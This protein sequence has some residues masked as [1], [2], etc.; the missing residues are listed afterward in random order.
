MRTLWLAVI[1]MHK[2]VFTRIFTMSFALTVVV[3]LLKAFE[4]THPE[5]SSGFFTLA[6]YFWL[7][8][9]FWTGYQKVLVLDDLYALDAAMSA[10]VTAPRLWERLQ[11]QPRGG[12]QPTV[13]RSLLGAFPWA[14]L[15]PAIPRAALVGFRYSQSFLLQ[16]LLKHLDQR[17]EGAANDG[18][19]LIGACVLVY[20][21]MFTSVAY[22]GYL[23]NR[24]VY[25]TR[26]CL[27]A[28]VYRKT[29][30]L[31]LAQANDASS[32]TLMSTDVEHIGTGLLQMHQIWGGLVEVALG[33]W[34]LHT[35]IGVASVVPL[36]LIVLCTI[37]LYFA[38]M[39]VPARQT[40]WMEKIQTRV[41]LTASAISDMKTFKILGAAGRVA[42]L[43][44]TRRAEEIGAGNQ[45]R[46]LMLASVVLSYMPISLS[47]VVA[48]AATL[49][50]FNVSSLFVSLS[51]IMLLSSPL[52][53]LF[54]AVP[55]FLAGIASFRRIDAYL[56]QPCQSDYR[57]FPSRDAGSGAEAGEHKS[58][59]ATS[60]TSSR[61]D[62]KSD[63]ASSSGGDTR[64]A[65]VATNASFG[66]E[67]DNMI[68]RDLDF[69]I[70]RGVITMI[71]GPTASGKSTLCHALLGEIPIAKGSLTA[72]LPGSAII[73]Y[74]AQTAYLPG[75]TIA[76]NIV[77][78][79]PFSREKY[80]SVLEAAMLDIDV[81]SLPSGHDTDVG[82]NGIKLIGGQKQRVSLARALYLESEISVFDDALSGL[83]AETEGKIFD[84]VFGPRGLI[85][86]KGG[87]A[88]YFTNSSRH[89]ALADHIIVL[90]KDGTI[91]QQGLAEM[92]T[93][94]NNG[95]LLLTDRAS[96]TSADLAMSSDGAGA[97]DDVALKTKG[98]TDEPAQPGGEAENG[99]ILWT[100]ARKTG[101]FTIYL[102]YL[103]STAKLAS[104]LV[105]L[106]S[107][108]A[109]FCT[110]FSTV[111]MSYWAEDSLHRPTAF[112]L[113]IYG[114]LRGTELIG[115]FGA[116]A[117]LLIGIV[118]SSGL[119][120][121]SRA[122]ATVIRAPLSLF[123]DTDTGTVANLFSQDMTI[124]DGELPM[125]LLNLSLVFFDLLGNCF[126]IAVASPYIL[127]SYPVLIA[128]LYFV[129]VFYL[130]TSR[131]L[132]LMDLEAKT[133]LYTHFLD[134][135]RGPATVRAHATARLNIAM[136]NKILD[137]SQR[138]AYLLAMIQQWLSTV[139]LA[140]V[141]LI[142]TVI[143]ALAVRLGTNPGFTGASFVTL[144]TLSSAISELMQGYTLVETSIGAVNRLRAF[145]QNVTPEDE[146]DNDVEPPTMALR[147][148]HAPCRR[149]SLIQVGCFTLLRSKTI[150]PSKTNGV[151]NEGAIKALALTN[152]SLSIAPGEKAAICEERAGENPREWKILLYVAAL[153]TPRASAVFFSHSRGRW[154]SPR[155]VNHIILRQR[156]ITIP[157]E[158]AFLPG[159]TTIR[160]NLDYLGGASDEDC[161][162]VVAMAQLADFVE[163][164]GGLDAEMG[165]DKLS[166]GQKQL[167]SLARAMLRRRTRQRQQQAVGA[168]STDGG[169]L[170]VDEL[171]SRLDADT[172][173]LIQDIIRK[174]FAAYTV[175][176]IAHRLD[177]VM[178]LC[179]RVFVL[180]RGQVVEVDDPRVLAG[181]K[182]SQFSKL[183]HDGN[184]A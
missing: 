21:G 168:L 158:L 46:V 83:D 85:H 78:F 146:D 150:L 152:L 134:T 132:R 94:D 14:F 75:G 106:F 130:R 175:V 117:F 125:A 165:A 52:L 32:L 180:D 17:P 74:C 177:I 183:Y 87:T 173:R 4:K 73:A 103:R 140:L 138:P 63:L 51:F 66:W 91:V 114:M 172:D 100:E 133:P 139:L 53:T 90:G 49:R 131:Q 137:A 15:Q 26:A 47:P 29:T 182:Q 80:E 162:S 167:F 12:R 79:L 181:A 7:K 98:E 97:P 105:L 23:N 110:N 126:V 8:R 10:G 149:V 119:N 43:V 109:G 13:L 88:I 112:Y 120:L 121:H 42:D 55:V 58:G 19:G 113:G 135:L 45:F 102:Y 33:C 128:I 41:A 81:A 93:N 28:I 89:L 166:T 163:E 37:L 179:D 35:H 122:I 59:S 154:C 176:I 86:T 156:I 70:P 148:C 174:D 16:A 25:I 116:S 157:Q 18:Y 159:N 170:L 3:L 82:S 2:I 153:A 30:D 127:A 160:E 99:N 36:G 143:T 68:L 44:Q 56:A 141:G 145:S 57:H 104:G 129:Q 184:R 111:W 147:G 72:G 115:I 9:L 151:A 124:I 169:L 40:V 84:R 11:R 5:E 67:K 161:T 22:F 142:A 54:Q 171:N 101:D 1:S 65:F 27:C 71:V 61:A 108:L 62:G 107:L 39:F 96:T 6:T 77:G 31:N 123:T 178:N 24:A 95:T 118:S 50:T 76:E 136:N 69:V 20:A 164:S 64:L 92:L 48:F 155:R 34:L 38:M 60:E 144:M